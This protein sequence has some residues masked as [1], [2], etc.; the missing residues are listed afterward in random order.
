MY[1]EELLCNKSFYWHR[2]SYFYKVFSFDGHKEIDS[3]KEQWII[4]Y[5][6]EKFDNENLIELFG[7]LQDMKREIRKKAI[8]CFLECNSNFELFSRLS[9]VSNSWTGTTSL[10]DKITFYEELLSEISGV[11]FLKHKKRI[12]D[13]IAKW[14]AIRNRE[15]VDEILMKLYQ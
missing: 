4:H 5:I 8:L 11:Q 10:T 13:E 1:F 15:E 14:K 7:I 3:R 2:R 6:R 12:R 9:L